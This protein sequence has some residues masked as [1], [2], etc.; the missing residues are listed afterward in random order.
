MNLYLGDCIDV[1]R[2]KIDAKSIDMI[3]CDLPYGVTANKKDVQIPFD[4]LW[5]QYE[6]VIKDNGCIAL[7]AQGLFYVDLVNSNRKLFRYDIVWNKVLT[8]GFLD[9]KRR[10]LRQHEQ[11]A[12]FYKKQ[13]VFNPQFTE[14][15]PLHSKGK[16][17]EGKIPKNQNY[18]KYAYDGDSRAGSTQKYPTSIIEFPKPHPSIAKHRTE[19]PVALLEWLIKTYTNKG[20]LVLDSCIGSG[21]S[22]IASCNTKRRFIG[23][24]IDREC[25]KSALLRLNEIVP[26]QLQEGISFV[27]GSL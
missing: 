15:K 5:E 6:R 21:T 3:L 8:T 27:L 7:F 12:I 10:P 19:K 25:Y 14:G 18:G 22:G 11:I 4:K 13:P 26:V 24:E 17:V 20:D 9:A 1:M 2:E 16:D 23:I